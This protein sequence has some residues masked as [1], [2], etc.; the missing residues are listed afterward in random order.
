MLN[1]ITIGQY[2][3]GKSF[4]HKMDPRMKILLLLAFMVLAFIVQSY[5]SYIFLYVFTF[6]VILA[7]KIPL[8]YTIKGMKP[9]LF[10]CIFTFVINLFTIKTGAEIFSMWIIHVHFDSLHISGLL[11]LK[12][13]LLVLST[14]LLTLTTTP[15]MLTDGLEKLLKPIGIFGI[16]AHEIAM[17]MTIALRFVP[18][19]IQ[20]TDRIIKAQSSRG[21]DFDTGNIFQKMKSFI[22][23]IIP[24]ISGAFRRAYELADAM[25][26][27]CYRGGMGRTRLRQLKMGRID[28]VC[29]LAFV[30]IFAAALTISYVI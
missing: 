12:L 9:I 10:L 5:Y 30:C 28:L 8:G 18:T 16:S 20:E 4:L 15:I 21:A 6:G 7:S 27:R 24:L 1:N 29:T 14:S 19:L 26:A 25:E 2:I 23:V 17:M 22:P 11:V 13:M 3:P